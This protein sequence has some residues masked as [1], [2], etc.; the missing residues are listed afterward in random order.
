MH[1]IAYE[2]C[3][4]IMYSNR[5]SLPTLRGK[6]LMEYNKERVNKSFNLYKLLRSPVSLPPRV[7][8]LI[9]VHIAMNK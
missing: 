1:T 5:T 4:Y 9:I 6:C 3:I 7:V 8:H 2:C